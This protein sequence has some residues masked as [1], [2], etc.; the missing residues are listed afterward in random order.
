[1]PLRIQLLGRFEVW[2]DGVPIPPAE[3]RG[4]KPRDLLKILL[5]ARGKFAANDQLCEWLWP[6]A[7]PDSAQA[8]LRSAVSDLRKLLEPELARGRDSAFIVTKREGYAFDLT[9]PVSVDAIDFERAITAASRPDLEAALASYRG[10]L[11]EEDPY[12]E[13]AI[14]ERER[15]REL[16]L[17]GLARLADLCLSDAD[18]PTAVSLC[19]QAL[20][21]DPSR[22]TLWRSLMRAHA[23]NGDRAAAL[24]TFESCRA[25]LARDLGVD[26]LPE[27]LALHGQI[28]QAEPL[29]P[30]DLTGFRNLSG[31]RASWLYRFGAL[32]IV[33]WV[34]LTGAN[35]GLSLAGLMRGTFVSSGDPGAEAL[36]YLLAHPEA[37]AEINQRLYLLFPLGLLLLPG[38]L[39]WFFALRSE[40]GLSAFA[41]VGVSLGIVDVAAQTLSRAIALAQLTVLPPTFTAASPDQQLVLITLWD[42]LRQLASVFGVIGVIA[43][44]V[45]ISLLCWASQRRFHP[46][47]AWPGIGLAG[48]TLLYSFLPIAL[49]PLGLGLAIATY[50]WF[51]AL[52]VVL[53]RL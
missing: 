45:A 17:D 8:N 35:L 51:M 46:L 18:Y 7:D 43:N 40:R 12:A 16:R 39:A 25:A 38:Y 13:W 50:A 36:P 23:L 4:Q 15:L 31:L 53:W 37:L 44:P 48:L 41:W 47:L 20:A 9:A 5:L 24:R 49:L 21:F 28:L 22:E 1:L 14:R 33:L 30:E 32:G 11:L 10:D 42:V 26:P 3:W 52:A 27:T 34:A 29:P 19:E 2:R 6:E